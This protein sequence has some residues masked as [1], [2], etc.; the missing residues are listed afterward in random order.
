MTE[1]LALLNEALAGR[2]RLTAQTI[3][4]AVALIHAP[5]AWALT[6]GCTEFASDALLTNDVSAAAHQALGFAEV[7]QIR[8]F[9]QAL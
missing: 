9:R 6:Q 4:T 3:V 8:C 7:E 1:P 2:Y 5:E